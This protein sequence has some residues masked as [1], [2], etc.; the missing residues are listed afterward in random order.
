M[1]KKTLTLSNGIEIPRIV[2]GVPLI[3]G[4]ENIT[5]TYFDRLITHSI[6][7]GVRSF[8]TSH[9]YGRSEE[10]LG[11]SIAKLLKKGIIKREDIFITSKIGNGQQK[12][13]NMIAS[14]DHSLK[15]LKLDYIDSML[16]HWPTPDHYINNWK[17]LEAIYETG[18]VKSI[19]ICNCVERHLI[20]LMESGIYYKPMIVQ[21][22]YHPFRTVPSLVK[23]CKEHNMA[24]QAYTS[25]CQMIP[26]VTG[27]KTINELSQKYNKTIAQIL[28]RWAIQQNIIPIFR[29]YNEQRIT[30]NV[31]IFDFE[32][33]EVDMQCLFALNIDYKYHPE[34]MNCPGF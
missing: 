10:M 31:Q 14:V 17:K 12:I 28:L 5:S 22:E 13:G 32:L 18:K 29:S 26:L 2:Q 21:F 16:L 20:A 23:I 15:S 34:S 33:D 19:G 27:N 24:I 8:D 25:L 9:D 1:N 3:L 6:E 7:K 4:L 11:K 30:Q